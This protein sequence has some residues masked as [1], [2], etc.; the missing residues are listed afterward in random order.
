MTV[1]LRDVEI[2]TRALAPLPSFNDQSVSPFP[3]ASS[4][5]ASCVP[6]YKARA[7]LFVTC[8]SVHVFFLALIVSASCVRVRVGFFLVVAVC[9]YVYIEV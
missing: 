1:C 7:L 3:L 6:C 9:M 5:C 2:L 8:E 4:P